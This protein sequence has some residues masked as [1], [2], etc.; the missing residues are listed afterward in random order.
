M[1][2]PAPYK[3]SLPLKSKT[4]IFSLQGMWANILCQQKQQWDQSHT[5][6]L[7]SYHYSGWYTK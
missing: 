5:E 7:Q 2:S 6:L 1:L 3:Q 4:L